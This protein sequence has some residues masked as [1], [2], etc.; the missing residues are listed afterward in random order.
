MAESLSRPFT[1][2]WE[3]I[4]RGAPAIGQHPRLTGTLVGAAALA[5]CAYALR[6]PQP[7]CRL[8]S[9]GRKNNLPVNKSSPDALL[10]DSGG[11]STGDQAVAA[12]RPFAR[13]SWPVYVLQ[14]VVCR[15]H[16]DILLGAASSQVLLLLHSRAAA[17]H[18]PGGSAGP[19]HPHCQAAAGAAHSAVAA[20][21]VQRPGAPAYHCSPITGLLQECSKSNGRVSSCW[22]LGRQ[23]C[24]TLGLV[25]ASTLSR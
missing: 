23:L 22:R 12:A 9:P 24:T 20:A 8:C 15:H 2:A 25:E 14:R 18:G 6:P 1:S 17:E 10:F 21:P 5:G 11:W 4:E 19:E 16:T 7:A 13:R 3:Q